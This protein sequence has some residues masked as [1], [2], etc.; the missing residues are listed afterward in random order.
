MAKRL[1]QR[2]ENP[3]KSSDNAGKVDKAIITHL[4][5][6]AIHGDG[7]ALY[8]LCQAVASGVLF[9]MTCR[10]SP[11]DAEDAAQDALLILC[12]NIHTLKNPKAFNGWLNSIVV[13]EISRHITQNAKQ[14]DV[15]SIDYFVESIAEENEIFL[16]GEYTI[17]EEDR[18]IVMDIVKQLPDR[19]SEA[20]MLHYYEGLTVTETAESMGVSRSNVNDYLVIA[21]NKIKV[22]IQKMADSS[23]TLYSISLLPIGAVITQVLRDEAA[24]LPPVKEAWIAKAVAAS[25][26]GASAKGTGVG[27]F[28]LSVTP[29][30]FISFIAA[31]AVAGGLLLA[32]VLPIRQS[33]LSERMVVIVSEAT[34][35][36]VFS[37]G[38]NAYPYINPKQATVRTGSSHGELVIQS[39]GISTE[40]GTILWS[41]EG[42]NANAALTELSR[43][44]QDGK[45]ILVFTLEDVNG[46]PYVLS[47][48][49]YIQR[50]NSSL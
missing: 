3:V 22:G 48:S 23:S 17:K 24:A 19:Q 13:H 18:K 6:K 40:D 30:I 49:F 35:D 31:L 8:A 9:R 14:A 34:G 7:D 4:A 37:G 43:N 38:D 29:A 46:C 1:R 36:I 21:R 45:Y 12:T 39:W 26:A 25:Q 47:H 50:D 33:D 44:G 27:A 2:Q 11:L 42:N 5:E 41:G 16:P 28:L 20:V 32:G 10:L 15:V